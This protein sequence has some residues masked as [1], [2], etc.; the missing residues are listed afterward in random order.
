MASASKIP[1]RCPR[2]RPAPASATGSGRAAP[3]VPQGGI[4]RID[5]QHH[6]RRPIPQTTGTGSQRVAAI[7]KRPRMLQIQRGAQCDFATRMMFIDCSPNRYRHAAKSSTATPQAT[8]HLIPALRRVHQPRHAGATPHVLEVS[9]KL[10]HHLPDALARRMSTRGRAQRTACVS[11]VRSH[12]GHSP[13]GCTRQPC[14]RRPVLPAA[15][16][17]ISSL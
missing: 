2:L 3:P 5:G 8:Q 11:R 16:P 12:L 6:N 10:R 1:A 17:W 4:T 9:I 14:S 15:A 13:E 7:N